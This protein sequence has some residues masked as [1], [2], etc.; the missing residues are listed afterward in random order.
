MDRPL[1]VGW[2]TDGE[3]VPKFVCDVLAWAGQQASLDI[4]Q[5]FVREGGEHH[6][7]QQARD[8][9]P[10]R[11]RPSRHSRTLPALL[12]KFIHGYEAFRLGRYGKLAESLRLH[13]IGSLVRERIPL[14]PLA[15]GQEAALR[16]PDEEVARILHEGFDLLVY[17]GEAMPQ[18]DILQGARL[19]VLVLHHGDDRYYR[20]GPPGFWEVYRQDPR[21]GFS[22][23]IL[24]DPSGNGKVLARGNFPT[25]TYSLAN[26]RILEL[27]AIQSLKDLL[28]RI[29]SSGELPAAELPIPYCGPRYGPPG[30]ATLLRY[31]GKQAMRSLRER[32]YRYAKIRDRWHVVYSATKWR[33]AE[34]WHGTPIPNPPGRFLAD[35]FILDTGPA[36]YCFVEEYSYRTGKG[37]ISAFEIRDD[38]SRYAGVAIDEPYHLSFPFLFRFDGALYMCPETAAAGEIRVYRCRSL[39]LEWELAAV[40]M[41]A[42]SAADSML[43][44]ANGRWWMLTNLDSSRIGDRCAELHLFHSD[45]PLSADWTAHPMNPLIVDSGRARNGGLILDRGRIFRVAQVHGGA[46]R[47]GVGAQVFEIIRIDEKNYE[48]RLVCALT[49]DFAPGVNGVHHMHADGRFTAWDF[50]TRERVPS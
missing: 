44:E 10:A 30:T 9:P 34:L 42:V 3:R 18:G 39:P 40:P 5:L 36:V 43:F 48:E 11:S 33:D 38:R 41:K 14:V 26:T 25:Q 31:I 8:G 13:D 28:L 4:A 49:P 2:L 16:F 24:C 29:S 47:Y 19:G 12:W 23:Q 15:S 6:R 1:K 21:T 22:L 32:W 7:G 37:S 45:S 27:R 20:G 50:R 46:D 35:P 17:S